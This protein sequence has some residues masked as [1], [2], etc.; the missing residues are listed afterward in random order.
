MYTVH[1]FLFVSQGKDSYTSHTLLCQL[2]NLLECLSEPETLNSSMRLASET[3]MR[4][5]QKRGIIKSLSE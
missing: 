5:D 3:G 4:E 1:V 2:M